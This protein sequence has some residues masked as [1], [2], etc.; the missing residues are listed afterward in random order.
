MF[1][2]GLS[3]QQQSG[4]STSCSYIDT[5]LSEHYKVYQFTLAAALKEFCVNTLGLKP[6]QCF[7]DGKDK[8]TLT[9]YVWEDVDI[10]LRRKFAGGSSVKKGFMSAREVMQVQGELQRRYFN[11]DVWI[12]KIFR[13]IEEIRCTGE[14]A[15]AVIT[16]IRHKNEIEHCLSSGGSIIH[17]A[18]KTNN[19][20]A[21]SEAEILKINWEIYRNV[22]IID[23]TLMSIEQKEEAILKVLEKIVK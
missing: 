22:Y 5:V 19:S 20:C 16:D 3:G 15:V 17:L 11:R 14:K 18:R 1:L 13:H 2:I 6:L 7:G 21:D 23:N 8:E 12:K 4:K 9:E 10:D